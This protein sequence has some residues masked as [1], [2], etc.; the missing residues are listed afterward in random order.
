[1]KNG[2]PVTQWF[3]GV[4]SA[5][6][7]KTPL[8]TSQGLM[9]DKSLGEPWYDFQSRMLDSLVAVNMGRTDLLLGYTYV[10]LGIMNLNTPT[11]F[12]LERLNKLTHI[13]YRD[14][15]ETVLLDTKK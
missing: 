14:K 13:A 5:A 1:M 2:L 7:F 11:F 4:V 12:T 6:D 9:I 8:S 15:R 10:N 3:Y